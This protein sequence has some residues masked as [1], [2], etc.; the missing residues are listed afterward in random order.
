VEGVTGGM[1][2]RGDKSKRRAQGGGE[3][4]KKGKHGKDTS[5]ERE[6]FLELYGT[7]T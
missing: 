3:D 4:V 2:E 7:G 6:G 5:G 1:D